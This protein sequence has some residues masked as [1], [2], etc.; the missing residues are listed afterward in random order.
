MSQNYVLLRFERGPDNGNTRKVT[1]V[2]GGIPEPRWESAERNGPANGAN[3]QHVYI[4][5]AQPDSPGVWTYEYL[6]A[7]PA[8]GRTL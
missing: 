2:A 1:A 4:R 7:E 5:R 3:V 6:R 8:N